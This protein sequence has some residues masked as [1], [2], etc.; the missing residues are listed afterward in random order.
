[1][2]DETTFEFAP[3]GKYTVTAAAAAFV[4]IKPNYTMTFS[5]DKNVVG[6]LDFTGPVMVFTGDVDESAKLFVDAVEKW[7]HGRIEKAYEDGFVAGMKKS[8]ESKVTQLIESQL[9][10]KNHA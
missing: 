2:S 5:N 9:K 1:M 8:Q 6:K 10:E 3:P 4:N 7:F